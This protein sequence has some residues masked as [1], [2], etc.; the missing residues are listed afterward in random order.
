MRINKYVAQATG[1]S[2]RAADTAIDHGRVTVN[3]RYPTAGQD[4]AADDI[5]LYEG[6]PITLRTTNTTILFHKP[7]GAIC[8]R[9]GQGG[10]TIYDVLPEQ[11]HKLK[12]VGRLDKH[13]SGLLLLTDDGQLAYELT[14]PSHQKDKRYEVKLDKPLATADFE[15]ITKQG[16]PLEDGPSKLAL[17][18]INDHHFEWKITMHEGRNRQIRRTF[19][20]LGYH[21]YTLHRTHFGEYELGSLRPGALKTV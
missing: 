20:A 19:E 10:Q 4:V 17:E 5:V 1:L 21:V 16:V 15:A 14:H 13:T 18:P 9:D 7:V 12:P 8:S 2:R 11:Y 6:K 3:D